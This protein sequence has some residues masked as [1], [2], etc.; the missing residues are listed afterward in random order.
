MPEI[1]YR[2][3][4]R[5][6]PDGKLLEERDEPYEVSD[7]ELTEEDILR[8]LRLA[9]KNNQTRHALRMIYRLFK[10]KIYGEDEPDVDPDAG[11]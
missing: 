9:I 5:Y 7:E 2:K 6:A 11:V 10:L 3:V 4:R 1:R 8:R